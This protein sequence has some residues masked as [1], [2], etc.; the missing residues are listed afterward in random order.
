MKGS[1]SR[2]CCS[3][4]TSGWW[5]VNCFTNTVGILLVEEF[6]SLL[7]NLPNKDHFHHLTHIHHHLTHIHHHHTHIHHHLNHIHY[8]LTQINPE[9]TQIHDQ[10]IHLMFICPTPWQDIVRISEVTVCKL[11]LRI[12]KSIQLTRITLIATVKYFW[13]WMT[14]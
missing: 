3:G 4:H 9:L 11:I 2:R 6:H 7:F 5:D 10:H 1:Q 12:N 14:Y 13:H 8:H